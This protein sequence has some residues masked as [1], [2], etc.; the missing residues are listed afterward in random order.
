MQETTETPP[1]LLSLS[2]GTT[3]KRVSDSQPLP[4]ATTVAA[5]AKSTDATAIAAVAQ[6]AVAIKAQI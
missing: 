6:N 4:I 2:L 1:S 5:T 3:I